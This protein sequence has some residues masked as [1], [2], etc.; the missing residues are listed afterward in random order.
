MYVYVALPWAAWESVKK[1]GYLDLQ[2]E[3]M[4]FNNKEIEELVVK[5]VNMRLGNTRGDLFYKPVYAFLTKEDACIFPGKY[6]VCKVLVDACVMI[7][8]DTLVGLMNMLK[9][10]GR[11]WGDEVQGLFDVSVT[12]ACR[13]R[14]FFTC[15][16][17]Y[18]IKKVWVYMYQRRLR[19]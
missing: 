10:E 2:H 7:D 3:D 8:D 11:G 4:G 12:R 17:R 9:S 18:M 16:K 6:I 5:E 15:L 1:V 19:G 14:C 13:K